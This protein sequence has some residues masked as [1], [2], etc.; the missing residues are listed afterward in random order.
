MQ[1]LCGHHS[2]GGHEIGPSAHRLIGPSAHRSSGEPG[3]GFMGRWCEGLLSQASR[4]TGETQDSELREV[5]RLSA[6][7]PEIE[8]SDRKLEAFKVTPP[9]NDTGKNNEKR[10]PQNMLMIRRQLAIFFQIQLMG[11][12]IENTQVNEIELRGA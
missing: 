4:L 5:R 11:Q 6:Q 10:F 8:L 12:T 1:S 3:E 7:T 2:E 9:G